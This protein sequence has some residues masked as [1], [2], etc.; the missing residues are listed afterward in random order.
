MVT[1]RVGVLMLDL[2]LCICSEVIMRRL[3][4]S[5]S[6]QSFHTKHENEGLKALEA[7]EEGETVTASQTSKSRGTGSWP[8]P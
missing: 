5:E 8:T 6:G 4:E 7:R 1:I 3:Q 2:H